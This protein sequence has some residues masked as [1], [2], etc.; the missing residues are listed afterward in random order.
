MTSVA[1]TMCVLGILVGFVAGAIT[2][3]LLMGR[4]NR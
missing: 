3:A 1:V 4:P 2:V